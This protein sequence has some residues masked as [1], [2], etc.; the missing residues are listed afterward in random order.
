MM[1]IC[2]ADRALA[3][4]KAGSG[5]RLLLA[6]SVAMR[7]MSCGGWGWWVGVGRVGGVGWGWSGWGFGWGAQR[8][9]IQGPYMAL[10]LFKEAL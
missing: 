3:V 8:A 7:G 6:W 5:C 9:T 1:N 2:S 4:Y 10:N